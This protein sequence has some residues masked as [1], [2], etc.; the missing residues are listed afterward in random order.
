MLMPFLGLAGIAAATAAVYALGAIPLIWR[1][2]V[3]RL[4]VPDTP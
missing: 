1:L 4:T 3:G 2:H